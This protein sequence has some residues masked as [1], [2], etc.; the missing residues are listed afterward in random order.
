M[1]IEQCKAA[2]D[3]AGLILI[4]IDEC[5]DAFY[6]PSPKMDGTMNPV[7]YLFVEA[8]VPYAGDG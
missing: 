1:S 3:K 8:E 5:S 6:T 4:S 7:P 2:I